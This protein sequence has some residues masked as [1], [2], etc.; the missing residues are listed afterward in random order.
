VVSLFIARITENVPV[1]SLKGGSV[2]A[3]TPMLNVSPKPGGMV[4]RIFRAEEQD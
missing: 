2:T 1:H 3:S 4:V